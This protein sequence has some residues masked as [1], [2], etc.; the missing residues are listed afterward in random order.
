MK[1]II[2]PAVAGLTIGALLTWVLVAPEETAVDGTT[3]EIVRDIIVA[4][5]MSVNQAEELRKES[6][7]SLLTVEQIYEL[8]SDFARSEAMYSLAG[9]SD[10]AGLQRLI[11][12]A[13]RIA[14]KEDRSVALNI[15][16]FRLTELDPESALAL[17]RT[18]SFRGNKSHE[19]RVWIAWARRDLD[20]ALFAAKTQTT[21]ANSN[22]A[23][24][25]LY[26]AFGYMGNE[27]TDRIEKELGVGPDR[28]IRGRFIYQMADRSPSEAI[29]FI[30]AMEPGTRQEEFV[31]WLANHLSTDDPAFAES[32]AS[33]F[34]N[35]NLARNY[36]AI[37]A[38]NAARVDPRL[39]FDR[40]L[41]MGENSVTRS[42]FQSASSTLA[43][44]DL[45]AAL[46]YY[47]SVRTPEARH[48]LGRS[49]AKAMAKK[50]PA[51]ALAWAREN[52]TVEY[53]MLQMQVLSQ[54]A[55]NDPELAFTEVMA[56]RNTDHRRNLISQVVNAAANKDPA[57]AVAMINRI[58]NLDLRRNAAQNL[59]QQWVRSDPD[60]AVSWILGNDDRMASELMMQAT[61]VLI[62]TDIDAAIR[63][64]PGTTDGHSQNMR[65]QI[66][67]GLAQQRSP[68]DAQNFI[69]RFEGQDGYAQLQSAV[70]TGVAAG[71]PVA[72][73][74][75]VAAMP[76]SP[77]RDQVTAVVAMNWYQQDSGS[78]RAWVNG[79]PRNE[80]RDTVI[81]QMASAFRELTPAERD[82]IRS[83]G[84]D[85]LRSRAEM[86]M[87]Q[88]LMRQ[89]PERARALLNDMELTSEQRRQYE[90]ALDQMNRRF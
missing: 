29:A 24:R 68:A 70:I 2:L 18:E 86:N 5:K 32:Y 80:H 88:R 13:N 57:I 74:N 38:N 69:R 23:A 16:F 17:A 77:E 21:N 49:I 75:M 61:S 26:T 60:A 53:P 67:K 62:R 51:A 15:L 55:V 40:L 6:Y 30:N 90:E 19:Q 37:V 25:S 22:L 65:V 71:D 34:A 12:E 50:D 1:T 11:F 7:E 3:P 36:R 48:V 41:S 85:E 84:N 54:I 47:D 42:E 72:A 66:A 8:P 87:L 31:S 20:G 58:E 46:Q 4:P 35:E 76:P 63:L 39:I 45:E 43:A 9:R 64:L 44:K 14:D 33:L 89:N 78:A 10:S 81:S 52:E 28:N 56:M 27:T 73:T 79:M 59:V 82:L 83:I